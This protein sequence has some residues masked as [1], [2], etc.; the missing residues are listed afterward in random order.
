MRFADLAG[1]RVGV[2]GAGR[3]GLAA[4]RALREQEP[5]REVVV[6]TDA[7]VPEQEREAFGGG[8]A[9][10]DGPDGFGRLEG[11][12]VVIRSPG[13]SR[14]R[15]EVD[16]LR[17][18]GVELTTGT[19]LWFEEHWRE[20]VVAVTGT[21]GKSTT[22]SLIAH[23]LNESGVRA[24]LGGN[25]GRAPLDIMR[26]EP[27]PDVWVLEL[28]SFQAADLVRGPSIGVLLN[29]HPEH[30]DWHGTPE[31]YMADKANLFLRRTD[32]LAVLNHADARVAALAEKL[33]DVRW[34]GDERSLHADERG[35]IRRGDEL[36]YE[37]G[38]LRLRGVHNALNACAALTAVEELGLDAAALGDPLRSFEPLPHRLE[39][40]GTHGGVTFVND[41]IST[42]P[43]AATAALHALAEAPIALIAGGYER[44]QDYSGLVA[45]IGD[46]TVQL[47][48]GLPDTGRRI[49]AE[50]EALGGDGPATALAS[51]VDEAVALAAAG[52]SGGGTVLLSPAAPS[53]VQF[54]NFEERGQAFARAA[55]RVAA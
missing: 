10:A 38:T 22:S 45:A 29:V 30:L 55:A 40:V 9:F 49:V 15:P 7:P 25:V 34:F 47:V 17:S 26:V 1:R 28:S 18:T 50:I 6:Y 44:G 51:D 52:L 39:P 31:R 5:E 13:V 48:V 33:V 21:K 43:A 16:R 2:W 14:Y 32:T 4:H 53:Y 41:S 3:E 35:G 46:S 12:E 27:A 11:C 20:R 36:L 8:A 24:T 23:V 19:N 37:P 42:T 54:R